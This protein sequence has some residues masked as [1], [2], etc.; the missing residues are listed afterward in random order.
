MYGIFLSTQVFLK[1]KQRQLLQD[2][3][4][5]EVMR[6]IITLQRWFRTSLIRFHFLHKRDATMIIQVQHF[7]LCSLLN[8]NKK[9]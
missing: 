1:E 2:T 3:L 7:C 9:L 8:K 4:N 5:K 6:R